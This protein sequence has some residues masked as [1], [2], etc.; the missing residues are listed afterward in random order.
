MGPGLR[1]YRRH[2]LEAALEGMI[3]RRL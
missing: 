2:L 3:E 1:D